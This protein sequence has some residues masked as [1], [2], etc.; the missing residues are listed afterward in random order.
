MKLEA[1]KDEKVYSPIEDKEIRTNLKNSP[2]WTGLRYHADELAIA[3]KKHEVLY[4]YSIKF[5]GLIPVQVTN[6]QKLTR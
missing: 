4:E 2:I 5:D 3:K 1:Y 6:V